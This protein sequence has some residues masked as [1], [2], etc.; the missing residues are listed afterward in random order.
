MT[1]KT[2]IKKVR[3]GF[4]TDCSCDKYGND[5]YFPSLY[6]ELSCCED[7]TDNAGDSGFI[8][9]HTGGFYSK[10]DCETETLVLCDDCFFELVKEIKKK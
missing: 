9:Q 8:L 4:T 1:F 6:G 3:R 5:I 7:G 2:E 10:H